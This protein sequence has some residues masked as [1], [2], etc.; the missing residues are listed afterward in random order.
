MDVQPLE[1]EF[2]TAPLPPVAKL[3]VMRDRMFALLDQ[4]GVNMSLDVNRAKRATQAHVYR[5]RRERGNGNEYRIR[6]IRPG[7]S[8]IWRVK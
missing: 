2:G 7:W 4:L 5:Y 1:H 3:A 8:R 6:P